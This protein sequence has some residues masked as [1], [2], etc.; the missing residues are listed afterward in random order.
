MFDPTL[1]PPDMLA[2]LDKLALDSQAIV[3]DFLFRLDQ[4]SPVPETLYHYTN[5]A[6]LKGILESGK[7]WLSD[8]RSLNDPS[9]ISHPF[10]RV[11]KILEEVVASIHP[12]GA[13]FTNNIKA[14]AESGLLQNVAHFFVC[15][16]SS[17]P[18][19]LYQWQSYAEQGCGY[20]IAFDGK[21]L[22]NVFITQSDGS[23]DPHRSTLLIRYDDT[24]LE[25]VQ[26]AIVTRMASLV[27]APEGRKDLSADAINAY[28][29]ELTVR[30]LLPLLQ[31]VLSFKHPAYKHEHEFRFLEIH[32]MDQ[33][34]AF[35]TRQRANSEVRYR[36]FNWRS[37]APEAVAEIRVGP[38]ADLEAATRH[39][40]D[41]LP[42]G[43]NPRTIPS[44]I[45]FRNA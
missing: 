5:A 39:I 10:S 43:I 35:L 23:P 17:E 36:E 2:E 15:S 30:A 38:A 27:T 18:D 1:I 31:V 26:R 32:R 12:A 19:D 8:I 13:K 44:D 28:M 21:L 7:L 16:F 4:Q 14:F 45:P 6:G 42:A 25:Q 11:I 24:E 37:R 29:A 34:P 9:E 33:P 40:K 22:E 20:A 3:N 41:C